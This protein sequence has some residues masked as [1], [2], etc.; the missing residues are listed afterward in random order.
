MNIDEAKLVFDKFCPEWI[1]DRNEIETEQ[2]VRIQVINRIL[3]EVLGWEFKDIKTEPS[4]NSGYIDYLMKS[5]NR[6]RFIV[7]A[8][9]VSKILVDTKNPRIAFY[10]AGG[11]ALK[12]AQE[13]LE[14]AKR[15]CTDTGVLFSALTTGF[16]WIGYWA[17]R[18]DGKAPLD[19]KVVVFPTLESI[20]DNFA[21]FYDLFSKEGVINNLYQAHIHEAEGLQVHHIEKLVSVIDKNE[22]R[23]L[24]KSKMSADLESIFKQ[25]FSTMSGINDP[26]MLAKCFVE[27]KESREADV[28]LE[29][30][31]RNLINRIDLVNS[32]EGDE[33]QEHIRNAVESQRGEFVLV[34]G[35]KGAGKSTFIDRFFRLILE[36]TLR[37]RCLVIRVDLADSDGEIST[38][39]SW[40]TQQMKKEIEVSFFGSRSPTYEELQGIFYSEYERWRDGEHKFLYTRDKQEFKV[41]FGAYIADIVDNQPDKYVRRLLRDAIASRKLMPSIIFDNTDHFPQEFQ[42]RIFQYAQSIHRANFSFVI[43]PITDRTIWQL[44]KSGPFQS[45]DTRAFYLPVP[46]TKEVLEKRV[47]FL[48]E[49]LEESKKKEK[50]DYFLTKGI[51]LSISDLNAFAACIDDVFVQ[52]EYISRMVGW[53][54]NHDIRRSLNISQRI[55]TSP[56]VS[57]E[58]LIK[59]YIAENR[60]N[61]PRVKIKQ[62]LLFGDYNQFNQD[63]NDYI[64]NVFTVRSD[65]VTTPLL[66]LSILRLLMDKEFQSPDTEDAYLLV[67]EIQ[68]YFEPCGVLRRTVNNH[69]ID[70]LRYRLIEPYD[71]TDSE[72]YEDQRVRVTH[73]GQIHYEFSLSD[74][75]YLTSMALMTEMRDKNLVV[76]I[77]DIIRKSGKMIKED[78]NKVI[79]MFIE[80]LFHEDERSIILPSMD[81]YSGQLKMRTELRAK[82]I[83]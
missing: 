43:C 34:I 23:L 59:L 16:E 44:S 29:K 54:S 66:K 36:K 15:Y 56:V 7:E 58:D 3:T 11:A 8:K 57:M 39:T 10:K 26:E 82:W 53:L 19:G 55:I 72:V 35:N 18:T 76:S 49:K 33:L 71:P 42:E 22:I 25:F 69:I 80:Y 32:G 61:I 30:I 67:E 81:L 13:G 4:V 6:N 21:V 37:E 70:L 24:Q 1:K 78:W 5:D 74:E 46:S 47:S 12:S 28:N 17:V 27:S 52:T 64:L 45:Y 75:I 9:R 77:K 50:V 73:S 38:I 63:S 48:K 65:D 83:S 20:K 62:A 60:L 51:R 31:A 14:Q 68:N 41:R 79:R 40:L 2:D